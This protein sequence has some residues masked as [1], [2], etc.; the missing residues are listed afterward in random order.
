M[1][2]RILEFVESQPTRIDA[3]AGVIRGVKVLGPKSANGP[4]HHNE[5]PLEMR[6][7]SVGLFNG[8]RV[9]IGHPPRGEAGQ[10]RPYQDAMGVIRDV[11]ERGDGLYGTWHFPPKHVLAPSICWDAANNPSGLGFSIN[12]TAGK[13]RH[14]GSRKIIESIEAVHSV[15]LV[16]KAATVK[17][18]FESR[19]PDRPT[20]RPTRPAQR[21]LAPVKLTGI[22]A[23][24]LRA[25][26]AASDQGKLTRR[27]R[28]SLVRATSEQQ[29]QDY[30]Q[31]AGVVVMPSSVQDGKS[32]AA[33]CAT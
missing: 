6:Q 22:Y 13:I 30:L 2:E 27:L 4:P 23:A 17:G 32:L 16:S 1:G 29:I 11:A 19:R 28:E 33:W 12:A 25:V 24:R 10:T 18:L 20:R 7:K 26:D 15:D 3:G 21:P 5:Y 31:R 8:S 14:D 9:F